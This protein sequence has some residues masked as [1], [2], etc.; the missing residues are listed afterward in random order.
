MEQYIS[1]ATRKH[2][3]MERE[4]ETWAEGKGGSPWGARCKTRSQDPRVTP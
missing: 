1:K 4:G 2:L 3:D